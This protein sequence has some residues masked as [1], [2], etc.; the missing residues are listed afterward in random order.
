MMGN[1][2]FTIITIKHEGI[3]KDYEFYGSYYRGMLGRNL[4]KR[5]CILKNTTCEVCPLVDKCLYMLSFEKYK[6]TLFLP[7]VINKSTKN[8]LRITLLGTFSK[9]SKM[10]LEAFT[11]DLKVKQSGF[12]N[13]FLNII[14]E[15]E[16]ILNSNQFKN[17]E[18]KSNF[19]LN[20]EFGRFKRDS[21][22][23]NCQE[24]DFDDIVKAI[25]RRIYLTNKFYGKTQ[26]EIYIHSEFK[27]TKIDCTFHNIA[28]YSNRKKKLMSI[29][30]T[31]LKFH[32]ENSKDLYRYIYLASILNIGT[33]ASMGFGQVHV[34]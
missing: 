20:I 13:P 28:R 16:F 32:I 10:Y 11:R 4:K 15:E 8:E 3:D 24:I 27:A 9:F 5:F 19:T 26:D 1:F 17:I 14:Q 30:C 31:N 21:K 33:N 2:N 25:E 23:L 22:I 18:N 34:H 29:P 7:Y 6:D 12:Y